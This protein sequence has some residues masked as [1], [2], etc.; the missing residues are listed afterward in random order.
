M[1]RRPRSRFLTHAYPMWQACTFKE[2]IL[3]T[4][5]VVISLFIL[6]VCLSLFVGHFSLILLVMGCFVYHTVLL[7]AK[8][9]ARYKKGKP[10]NFI[11]LDLSK[12]LGF[13][14]K[15]RLCRR[16][17]WET[18]RTFRTNGDFR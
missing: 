17:V 14:A 3:L 4:V 6:S 11:L 1:M 7:S 16:G 2:L 15:S 8:R 5:L 9:F 13:G 18:R 12:R 10:Y